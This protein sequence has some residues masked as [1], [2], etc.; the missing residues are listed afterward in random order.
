MGGETKSNSSQSEDKGLAKPK[1]SL[2]DMGDLSVSDFTVTKWN[3]TPPTLLWQG[4]GNH[5]FIGRAPFQMHEPLLHFHHPH[6]K[7]S[8]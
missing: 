3:L 6:S 4:D 7:L 2:T 5:G 8:L 1:N